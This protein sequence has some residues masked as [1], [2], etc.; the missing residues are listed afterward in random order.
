MLG[1]VCPN[2]DCCTPLMRSKDR[3]RTI[4]VVC[5]QNDSKIASAVPSM[6]KPASEPVPAPANATVNEITK[7][8]AKDP[9]AILGQYLLS[10]WAMMNDACPQCYVYSTLYFP[11]CFAD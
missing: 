4:C 5:E 1:D 6:K 8:R 9:S 7:P 11:I 2:A 3:T 10:G